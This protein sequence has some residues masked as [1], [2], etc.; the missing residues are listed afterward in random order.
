MAEYEGTLVEKSMYEYAGL[1]ERLANH[2]ELLNEQKEAVNPVATVFAKQLKEQ[3]RIL[4]EQIWQAYNP[5]HYRVPHFNVECGVANRS[6]CIH[7]F[8]GDNYSIQKLRDGRTFIC[9][10]DGMGTGVQAWKKSRLVVELLFNALNVGFFVQSALE[11][12]NM[13]FASNDQC[14]IPV[15]LD[16]CVMDEKTGV[17]DFV[18]LGAVSTFVK[19]KDWIEMIQSETMP[20]GVLWKVDFDHTIKKMYDRDYVIMITD[21][22]LDSLPG[23]HK[24]QFFIQLMEQIDCE[25]PQ[26]IADRLLKQIEEYRI[27]DDVTIIVARLYERT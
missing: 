23:E 25:K 22:V 16:L 1:L 10:A 12:V 26:D 15:T 17:A 19:R 5:D 27:V 8:S 3:S 11:L 24:E 14:G 13:V 7:T 6:K 18:K 9:L 21:G 4:K 20:M 2:C